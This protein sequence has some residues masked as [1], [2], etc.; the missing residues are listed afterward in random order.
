IEAEWEPGTDT[1]Y[2]PVT[3]GFALGELI[4][5][6]DGREPRDFLRDEIFAPLRMAASLGTRDIED[7]LD[8]VCMPEAMSEV[9]LADPDGTEA[10]TSDIVRRFTLPSTLRGQ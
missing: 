6:V 7:D 3:Y 9:T 10:R 2:H 8:L 5:R 4:R 1:G